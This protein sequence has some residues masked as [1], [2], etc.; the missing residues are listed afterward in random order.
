MH[1]IRLYLSFESQA[2]FA[3]ALAFLFCRAVILGFMQC[4]PKP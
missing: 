3:A 4:S 1:R 2:L